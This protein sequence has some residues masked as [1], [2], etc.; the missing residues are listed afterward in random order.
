MSPHI[1]YSSRF[2]PLFIGGM[3][4]VQARGAHRKISFE[5]QLVLVLASSN[6]RTAI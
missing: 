5:P 6:L 4:G 2:L 3:P 1:I